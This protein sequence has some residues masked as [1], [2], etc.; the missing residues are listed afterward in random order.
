MAPF[1]VHVKF[2]LL[3]ILVRFFA[4]PLGP[5]SSRSYEAKVAALRNFFL[6]ARLYSASVRVAIPV[7]ISRLSYSLH[8]WQAVQHYPDLSLRR[9][10]TFSGGGSCESEADAVATGAVEASPSSSKCSSTTPMPGINCMS[11]L[12]KL[13]QLL[14][15]HSRNGPLTNSDLLPSLGQTHNLLENTFM[16]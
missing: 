3:C 1:G 9:C 6:L 10:N 13:L 14:R 5:V 12:S 15:P 7:A 11:D 2:T 8:R 16:F 4:A